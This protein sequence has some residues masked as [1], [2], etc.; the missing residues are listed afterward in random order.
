MS[1]S[2]PR[3]TM[4]LSQV[5][6]ELSARLNRHLQPADATSAPPLLPAISNPFFQPSPTLAYPHIPF[7]RF[8]PCAKHPPRNRSLPPDPGGRGSSA[9]LLLNHVI[10]GA[11]TISSIRS[12]LLIASPWCD[13]PSDGRSGLLSCFPVSVRRNEWAFTEVVKRWVAACFVCWPGAYVS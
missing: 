2:P 10:T 13:P 4:T 5:A 6:D 1:N 9:D 11:A 3:E 7:Q 8:F 12:T